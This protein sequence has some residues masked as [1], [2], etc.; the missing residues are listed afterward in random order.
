M[1][2]DRILFTPDGDDCWLAE[3]GGVSFE[4]VRI[5]HEFY[6]A[7]MVARSSREKLGVKALRS[8]E[9]AVAWCEEQARFRGE[10]S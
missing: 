8:H 1:T 5:N 6:K 2:Q 7:K 10:M 3:C 4:I 9:E